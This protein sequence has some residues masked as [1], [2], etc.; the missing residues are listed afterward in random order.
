MIH[1]A[2]LPPSFWSFALQTAA[3]L[4][5]RLPTQ[6]LKMQSP[7]FK[8]FHKNPNLLKLRVFG[9]LCFPWLK[10]YTTN[11]LES[12]SEPCVFLGYSQSQSA[13]ICFNLKTNKFHNS[14][15]VQFVE[16]IF[17]LSNSSNQ[18]SYPLPLGSSQ[19]SS[20][21]TNNSSSNVLPKS[22]LT[23]YF[24]STP[25]TLI[26]A[27]FPTLS[28]NQNSTQSNMPPVL[29]I[30][31]TGPI[32]TQ[33]NVSSVP[34]YVP[35]NLRPNSPTTTTELPSS[36]PPV[37][38]APVDVQQPSNVIV[39]R[40]KHGIV[41]P[42]KLFTYTV[43]KYPIPSSIEPSC[44][45][46]A[47]KHD[48]WKQ[49][50]SDEFNALMKNGTWTL[51]PPQP[52][53]NIIGNKW[54]FRLKRNTDGT[55]ARHKARLV[56]KGFHQRPGIDFKDTFSP[57]I[58]PQTIKL[59]LCLA[60]TN[61]WTLCQMD[62]N[63]AFLHG[64]LNEDV[65]MVQPAGF[66]HLTLPNH[67]CKLHK[68]LYGL[69]QAPRAWFHALKDFLLQY[70]FTNSKSDNSLFIY[71]NGPTV[72]YF[73]VYVDDLLLT[74]NCAIFL[75]KFKESLS[76]AFSLKDLGFPNHFLGVEIL[77]T[78]QGL[79]LTQHHYIRQ[80][81]DR[82]NMTD[83]KTVSTPM[84]TSFSSTTQPD[85]TTCDASL[86]RSLVGSLHYLA[87]TRPDVAFPVNKLSQNMQN[88]TD[89]HMQALKRVLRY[90]KFTIDHGLHLTKSLS[91]ALTAFCDADWG[92]DN[93]DRKS[94]GAY[95]I[96]IGSNAISWSCKKQSTVARSSTEAEYRTIAF[97][98]AELL[99]L[100]QLLNELG[101]PSTIPHVLSDNI[102]ATYLC[103]NPVYHSRM[104][105]LA[106][107][108]HFVRDLVSQNK[109]KVSHVPSSHQL[110]DL[111]TKPLSVSRHN[112]LKSKIGVVES[113]SIL[114]GRVGVL[115]S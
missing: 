46:Q 13:Y 71:K 59:I 88:P 49:A 64:S 80:M 20:L 35:C 24:P 84:S 9:C 99:W 53:Y 83:A 48:V 7:F 21:G 16:S 4:I 75:N 89:L 19:S 47:L 106:I 12:R 78:S 1:Q 5:N 81:L 72:A 105:H 69:K 113:A 36:Q 86:Y 22:P 70:G 110:A 104:K 67:I 94:T 50:M 60:L 93:S 14:R 45:T 57:V 76:K 42:K 34:S 115:I 40:S 103:S 15:D 97:T 38:E 2:S 33:Q 3:Y 39:T 111:L 17:P 55:I 66:V 32:S 27:H 61:G 37:L 112:F 18:T 28:T 100:Q 108:Y 25:P 85:S 65:Y 10:P 77:P 102:G 41:K 114:R 107:D 95:I 96:Y 54:V 56:A 30:S 109:L 74:G 6:N 58:K 62:V 44:V 8:L 43:S 87:L 79:F 82:A 91:T 101:V 63:N 68:A 98:T 26:S 11:K 23:S 51:V 52:N 73:L 90:L 31:N 29:P 92:G